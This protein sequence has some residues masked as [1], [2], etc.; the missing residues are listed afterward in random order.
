MSAR[1]VMAPWHWKRQNP[2]SLENRHFSAAGGQDGYEN[3]FHQSQLDAISAAIAQGINSADYRS[4]K[5][6]SRDA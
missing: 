1:C 5:A 3:E 6:R 2:M 4:R